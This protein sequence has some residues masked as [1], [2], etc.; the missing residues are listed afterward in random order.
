MLRP[1]VSSH[2]TEIENKLLEW[3]V[4]IWDLAV[5]YLQNCSDFGQSAFLQVLEYFAGQS[6]KF[7]GQSNTKVNYSLHFSVQPQIDYIALFMKSLN[8]VS[9]V[10]FVIAEK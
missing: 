7:S 5:F 2:E 4:R 9:H 10:L 3:R 6:K 1:Y 8:W